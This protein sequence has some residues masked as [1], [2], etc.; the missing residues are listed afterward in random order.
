MADISSRRS[1]LA[2]FGA[3][4]ISPRLLG[5]AEAVHALLDHILL[6]CSDLESGVRFIEERLGVR[7][8]FGGVHPGRGT[9]NALLSLG[10]RRY[11]EIIAPDPKQA[12]TPLSD[13]LR[14]LKAPRLVEWAAHPGNLDQFAARLRSAGIAFEGPQAGSR[15]RPGG[16]VLHWRTITLKDDGGVLPFFIEWGAD[17]PHPSADAPHGAELVEFAIS[18]PNPEQLTSIC[19]SLGLDVSIEQSPNPGLRARVAGR[20]GKNAILTS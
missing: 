14:G 7:A 17:S 16:R 12:G 13:N 3:A 19:K 20:N 15:K 5:K 18:G 1:F 4:L 8:V 9:Q 10:T 2:A 11:L 6:G